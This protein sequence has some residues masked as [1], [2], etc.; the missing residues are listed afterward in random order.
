MLAKERHVADRDLRP[1]IVV[2]S[3][4]VSNNDPVYGFRH[5]KGSLVSDFMRSKRD[6]ASYVATRCN[7]EL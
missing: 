4:R 1:D 2:A 6:R 5:W 7:S 3:R